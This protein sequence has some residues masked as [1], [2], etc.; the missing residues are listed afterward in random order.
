MKYILEDLLSCKARQ[1][2][3]LVHIEGQVGINLSVKRF[4][5]AQYYTMSTSTDG[6]KLDRFLDF[7]GLTKGNRGS[8]SKQLFVLTAKVFGLHF[9]WNCSS[10]HSAWYDELD[11]L[12]ILEW[13]VVISWSIFL[14]VCF[15]VNR[16][17][18][19]I[20]ITFIHKIKEKWPFSRAST[21]FVVCPCSSQVAIV[22]W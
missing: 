10:K 13:P 17:F 5:A 3:A 6:L 18:F 12:Y 22:Q 7:W 21:Y 15:A 11:T 9:L 19:A 14:G 2:C 8:N 1:I 20:R 4:S 16:E